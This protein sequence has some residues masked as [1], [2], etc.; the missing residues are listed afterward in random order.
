MSDQ[1]LSFASTAVHEGLL[2]EFFR[3]ARQAGA[4]GVV[5]LGLWYRGEEGDVA[6]PPAQ[7][8]FIALPKRDDL[9]N[10]LRE[11]QGRAPEGYDVYLQ[12]FHDFTQPA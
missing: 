2:T 11:E 6:Q 8:T 3:N 4:A 9:Q 7:S 5:E 12:R 1:R 10:L